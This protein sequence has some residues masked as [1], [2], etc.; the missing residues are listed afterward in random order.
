MAG[1]KLGDGEIGGDVVTVVF[2]HHRDDGA[3]KLRR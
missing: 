1:H 3:A 2:R